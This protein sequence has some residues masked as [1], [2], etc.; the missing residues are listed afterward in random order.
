MYHNNFFLTNFDPQSLNIT[1]TPIRKN[2]FLCLISECLVGILETFCAGLS[3]AE[4]KISRDFPFSA[5]KNQLLFICF[6]MLT[7][8]HV[9]TIEAT[10][11]IIKTNKT[12]ITTTILQMFPFLCVLQTPPTPPPPPR[13][14]SSS[15]EWCCLDFLP[16]LLVT[17]L[18]LCWVFKY[19]CFVKWFGFF[20]LLIFQQSNVWLMVG[21]EVNLVMLRMD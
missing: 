21:L 13:A 17:L 10:S 7:C 15:G 18:L 11:S 20:L 3:L 8:L 19:Q 5:F 2:L 9:T 6:F 4:G 14:V 16:L 1:K 12:I